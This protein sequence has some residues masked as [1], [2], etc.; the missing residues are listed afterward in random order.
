MVGGKL[1]RD[2]G[3]GKRPLLLSPSAVE[4]E[5]YG[6]GVFQLKIEGGRKG[7]REG[8][9]CSLCLCLAVETE[10]HNVGNLQL[11]SEEAKDGGEGK[12]LPASRHLYGSEQSAWKYLK[13]TTFSLPPSLPP[14]LP[15]WGSSG[16]N[17]IGCE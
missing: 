1:G 16:R 8:C 7:G 10:R 13:P 15:T 2:A 11:G 3:Q 4:S 12:D 6:V 9:K 17:I 14:S 5:R